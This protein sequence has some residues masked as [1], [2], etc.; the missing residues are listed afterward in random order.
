M[1]D[2]NPLLNVSTSYNGTAARDFNQV[3]YSKIRYFSSMIFFS[4]PPW[5]K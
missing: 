5:T 1:L 4:L 2:Y 3:V